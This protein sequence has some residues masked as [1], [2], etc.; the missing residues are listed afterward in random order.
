MGVVYSLRIP[1]KLDTNK[2]RN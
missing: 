1:L 2:D